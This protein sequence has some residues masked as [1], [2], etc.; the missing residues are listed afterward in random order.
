MLRKQQYKLVLLTAS[1]RT[2]FLLQIVVLHIITKIFEPQN[3]YSNATIKA[4]V[5]HATTHRR[6]AV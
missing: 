6:A 1:P 3:K 2:V 4:V 5:S